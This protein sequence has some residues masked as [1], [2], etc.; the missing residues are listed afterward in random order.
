MTTSF[1]IS[2]LLFL[3]PPEFLCRNC[4]CLLGSSTIHEYDFENWFSCP[5]CKK[6]HY[7]QNDFIK[8]TFSDLIGHSRQL[9]SIGEL[10]KTNLK[11][12][13]IPPMR[14]LLSALRK[15]QGFVH[16]T[17]YGMSHVLLGVLKVVSQEIQVRGIVA[18]AHPSL[19]KE[20]GDYTDENP[21]LEL[22]PIPATNDYRNADQIPHQ[23]LI[24]IDGLLAFTGS[25]N[26]TSTAWR[27]AKTGYEHVDVMTDIGHIQDI[28]NRLFCK[29]WLK[30]NPSSE[31]F[32][33]EIPF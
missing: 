7:T 22:I 20:I 15:A 19:V 23:K 1:D 6:Y 9:A 3:D 16:L 5:E 2:S 13:Q 25:A 12:G 28:H 18:N 27:K 17:T 33:D 24:I 21:G 4:F 10:M 29:T 32:E 11:S 14:I 26:F 31:Y 30:L 8:I